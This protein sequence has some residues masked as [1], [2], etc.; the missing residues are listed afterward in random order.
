MR[1]R[2]LCCFYLVNPGG[3]VLPPLPPKP[4]GLLLPGDPNPG[5]PN[6]G[7][8]DGLDGIGGRGGCG[9]HIGGGG[10]GRYMVE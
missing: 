5:D 3:R 6:P 2:D 1:A 8:L 10:P 9:L 7:G 4:G